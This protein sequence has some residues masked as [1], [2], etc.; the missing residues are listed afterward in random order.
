MNADSG[1]HYTQEH[2]LV[3]AGIVKMRLTCFPSRSVLN[4]EQQV[5]ECTA[6]PQ[7]DSFCLPA[8]KPRAGAK[9]SRA[10]PQRTRCA[11]SLF[12]VRSKHTLLKGKV[13][14]AADVGGEGEK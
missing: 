3:F 2:M 1:P 5:S 11:D 6:V 9:R 4:K 8:V 10:A 13:R 12:L 7:P 14:V